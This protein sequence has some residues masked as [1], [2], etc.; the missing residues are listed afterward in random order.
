M[1]VY[2]LFWYCLI[3][4]V[5]SAFISKNKQPIVCFYSKLV[6]LKVTELTELIKIHYKSREIICMEYTLQH[7]LV[8]KQN[9][10]GE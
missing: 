8:S 2:F 10:M 7:N 5:L 9:S 3:L 6:L 1:F 4:S